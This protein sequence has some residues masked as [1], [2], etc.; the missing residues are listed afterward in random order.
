MNYE[1]VL[2]KEAGVSTNHRFLKLTCLFP[3]Y[4]VAWLLLLNTLPWFPSQ[5]LDQ[6]VEKGL[7]E[8]SKERMSYTVQK[9]P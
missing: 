7:V 8:L 2:R 3:V 4:F 6:R 1:R 9:T 5:K